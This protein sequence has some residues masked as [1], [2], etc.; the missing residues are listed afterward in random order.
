MNGLFLPVRKWIRYKG[1]NNYT[2]TNVLLC[3]FLCLFELKFCVS[4]AGLDFTMEV[5]LAL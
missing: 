2:S 3:S 5:S 4:Q 1:P